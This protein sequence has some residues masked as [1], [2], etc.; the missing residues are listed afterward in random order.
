MVIIIRAS[1]ARVV[2]VPMKVSDS[3]STPQN[4]AQ[5]SMTLR[6]ERRRDPPREQ[7]RRNDQDDQNGQD[8]QDNQD[9]QVDQ[10]DQEDEGGDGHALGHTLRRTLR[11]TQAHDNLRRGER[12][13]GP[14]GT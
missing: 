1:R 3:C 2:T 14:S 8:N 9:N 4:E 10:D 5:E 13:D 12:R 7:E 6:L 11:H